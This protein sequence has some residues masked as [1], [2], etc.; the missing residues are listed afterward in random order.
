M[1]VRV[2][3]FIR[4]KMSFLKGSLQRPSLKKI[5]RLRGLNDY[6]LSRSSAPANV[7]FENE[8]VFFAH[9]TPC[10]RIFNLI[11]IIKIYI[12]LKKIKNK[13]I[14]SVVRNIKYLL[15]HSL[16]FLRFYVKS[17]PLAK[18]DSLVRSTKVS[19]EIL[20]SRVYVN[21]S[22]RQFSYVQ[23]LSQTPYSLVILYRRSL[24]K[25]KVYGFIFSPNGFSYFFRDSEHVRR[26]LHT[27]ITID[28][29]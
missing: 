9:Y 28:I 26:K 23:S 27:F 5:F 16:F 24:P 22:R 19:A 14:K 25:S 20:F 11:L 3:I 18:C 13:H 4:T 21:F 1:Y 6:R 29:L 15:K 2:K 8:N 17:V 7:L 12:F 10:E